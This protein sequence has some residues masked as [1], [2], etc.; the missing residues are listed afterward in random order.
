MTGLSRSSTSGRPLP[1]L[2]VG[3]GLDGLF[4]DIDDVRAPG[5]DESVGV[6]QFNE[7]LEC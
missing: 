4:D 6:H 3:F 7:D 5:R 2:G 1:I